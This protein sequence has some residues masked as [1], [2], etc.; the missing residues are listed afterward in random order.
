MNMNR[1]QIRINYG[2]ANATCIFFFYH[3]DY[4]TKTDK[5]QDRDFDTAVQELNRVYKTY[6]RFATTRGV[7]K[8]FEHF[9]FERTTP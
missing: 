4:K 6:G 9:G 2:D 3:K 7:E 5:E 8:L 1:Y